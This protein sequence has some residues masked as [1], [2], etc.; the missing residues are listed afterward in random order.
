MKKIKTKKTKNGNG[1]DKENHYREHGRLLKSHDIQLSESVNVTLPACLSYP[2]M[3]CN[4]FTG[5]Y[6]Y[7][8]M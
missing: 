4:S 1:V 8:H 6:M 2:Y 7:I 3:E 5:M